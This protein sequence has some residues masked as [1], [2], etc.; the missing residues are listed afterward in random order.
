[1]GIYRTLL[2]EEVPHLDENNNPDEQIKEL[3]AAYNGFFDRGTDNYLLSRQDDGDLKPKTRRLRAV[4]SDVCHRGITFAEARDRFCMRRTRQSVSNLLKDLGLDDVTVTP[5][6]LANLRFAV[7]N[8]AD[9]TNT[10]EFDESETKGV[11]IADCTN[12]VY[13]DR[14][15]VIYLGMEQDWNVRVVGKRYLDA[16][17]ENR[18]NAMRLS[19]LLQ[20]GQSRLYLVNTTKDGK[21]ARPSLL[22]D[23]VFGR[24]CGSFADICGRLVPGRWVSTSPEP[25]MYRGETEMDPSGEFDEP[26]SKT[27]FNALAYCPRRYMFS[28]LLSDDDN[29]HSAF[30]NLIHSFAEL[31]VCHRDKVLEIGTDAIADMLAERFAGLSSPSLGEIDR[32]RIRVAMESITAY[33]DACGLCGVPLDSS[34]SQRAHPNPLMAA[35]GLDSCSS[36]CEKDE[37]SRAH[38]VHGH[39]DIRWGDAVR[40]YKTGRARDPEEIKRDM[41]LDGGSSSPDFQPLIYLALA[42][43][44]YP[45]VRAFELFYAMDGDQSHGG[46]YDF[47]RGVRRVELSD[48]SLAGSAF[49]DPGFRSV[50]LEGGKS[51]RLSELYRDNIDAFLAALAGSTRGDPSGW[52]GDPAVIS[53]VL[54]A[55]G[56]SEAATNRKSAVAAVDKVAGLL[57][58]GIV[59]AGDRVVVPRDTLDSFLARLDAMHDDV[60]ARS[61]DGGRGFPGSPAKG[62][63]CEHCPFKEA[64]MVTVTAAEEGCD[65]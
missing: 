11:V 41:M 10:E 47:T 48:Q 32:G 39:F 60:V 37:R 59:M 30:G 5:R 4:M 1:M 34:A 3:F 2:E 19:A 43:E 20:Q 62:C 31:Y 52:S 57:A 49:D 6:E 7:E 18:R 56:K 22:F 35:L 58:G 29:R 27:T 55:V 63:D 64:C 33:A 44:M 21:P 8:I 40:D 65:E 50:L 36:M 54:A 53:A 46:S 38:Q 24:K 17:E 42:M 26:F 45:G 15:V 23:T 12:S 9:L 25:P 51:V 61:R 16:E 13:I 28:T 14:P